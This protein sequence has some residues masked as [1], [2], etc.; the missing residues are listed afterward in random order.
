MDGTKTHDGSIVH[1]NTMN[2]IALTGDQEPFMKCV[3]PIQRTSTAQITGWSQLS[4]LSA[5]RHC[6]WPRGTLRQERCARPHHV[7]RRAG[8]VLRAPP[9][10][11]RGDGHKGEDDGAQGDI[12]QLL[13]PF[14]LVG[15]EERFEGGALIDGGK[16]VSLFDCLCRAVSSGNEN[17]DDTGGKPGQLGRGEIGRLRTP[18]NLRIFSRKIQNVVRYVDPTGVIKV[19]LL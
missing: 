8:I 10:Y 3:R 18:A 11:E 5:R 6:T 16:E 15:V 14:G 9:L 19:S 1:T 2:T 17:S 12:V 7:E 13:Q 4:W